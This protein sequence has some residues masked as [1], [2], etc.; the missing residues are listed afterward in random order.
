VT[1][2]PIVVDIMAP[3]ATAATELNLPGAEG[4]LKSAIHTK[5]VTARSLAH[6]LKGVRR[7]AKEGGESV[8]T[9]T[10]R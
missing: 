4:K 9:E 6:I 10:E 2:H 3:F 5:R 8:L 7:R 1:T